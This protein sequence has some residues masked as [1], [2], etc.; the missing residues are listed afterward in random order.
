LP[1]FEQARLPFQVVDPPN[2]AE[3]V[4]VL[5]DLG[6]SEDVC[7][8]ALR[9]TD[10]NPDLAANLLVSGKIENYENA[11]RLLSALQSRVGADGAAEGHEDFFDEETV[12]GTDPGVDD[13]RILENSAIPGVVGDDDPVLAEFTEEERLKIQRLQDMGFEQSY[14]VQ[15]FKACDKDENVTAN[16]LLSE[17]KRS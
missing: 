4:A 1:S 13:A 16:C 11:A 17:T 14:V 15:M 6:Y 5:A 3:L 12:V 7:A 10:F 2:M 8:N 9:F